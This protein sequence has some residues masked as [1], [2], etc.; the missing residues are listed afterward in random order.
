[1]IQHNTQEKRYRAS[2]GELQFF[3]KK[4]QTFLLICGLEM[5]FMETLHHF[6]KSNPD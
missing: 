1:M 5:L 6:E 4:N 3:V 2:R